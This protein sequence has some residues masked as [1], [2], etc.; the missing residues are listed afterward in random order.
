AES[1]VKRDLV[2]RVGLVGQVGLVRAWSV[3]CGLSRL[4]ASGRGR[5]CSALISIILWAALFRR[6][7]EL[8][9]RAVGTPRLRIEPGRTGDRQ[10]VAVA[11]TLGAVFGRATP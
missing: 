2:G 10:H 6:A 9:E 8:V 5:A 7:A 3:G 4:V 11:T 1:K